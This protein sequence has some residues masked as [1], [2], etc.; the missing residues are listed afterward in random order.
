MVRATKQ[1]EGWKNRLQRIFF[2]RISFA[3]LY[4][5]QGADLAYAFPCLSCNQCK[6]QLSELLMAVAVPV[7]LWPYR[8]RA[9]PL[10]DSSRDPVYEKVP[11]IDDIV[12]T[13]HGSLQASFLGRT[14]AATAAIRTNSQNNSRSYV[15]GREISNSVPA[16]EVNL[17]WCCCTN[18]FS[19]CPQ[20]SVSWI[21]RRNEVGLSS[22]LL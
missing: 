11:V 17:P 8:S 15:F 7:G 18:V 16:F 4:S 13:T 5:V 19:C 1:A 10:A 2:K 3:G 20:K 6:A 21:P 9:R 14:A 22:L 12:S